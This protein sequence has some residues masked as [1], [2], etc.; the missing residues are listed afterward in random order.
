MENTLHKTITCS[1]F[2]MFEMKIIYLKITTIFHHF[3][4]MSMQFYRIKY[5]DLFADLRQ[6]YIVYQQIS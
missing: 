2:L 3:K 6:N 1:S 5:N 4:L